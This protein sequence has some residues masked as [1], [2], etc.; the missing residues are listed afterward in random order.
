MGVGAAEPAGGSRTA[1]ARRRLNNG[2][3]GRVLLRRAA[4]RPRGGVLPV[5]ARPQRSDGV[6][7]A[8]KPWA[9]TMAAVSANS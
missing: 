8:R 9:S 3:G 5:Q 2:P 4:G 6:G 7:P 1:W